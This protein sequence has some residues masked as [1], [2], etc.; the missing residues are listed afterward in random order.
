[1][2]YR[3]LR[4]SRLSLPLAALCFVLVAALAESAVAQQVSRAEATKILSA[5][6]AS[7]ANADKLR[8]Y[9]ADIFRQLQNPANGEVIPTL[10]KD[11]ANTVRG[12]GDN[13][14]HRYFNDLVF[15]GAKAAIGNRNAPPAARY[16]ALL[17]LGDLNQSDAA[18]AIKPYAP[19]LDVLKLA[20][21]VAPDNEDFAFL[22]PA[23]IVGLTRFA[24]EK[25]IP[26]KDIP[27]ITAGLLKIVSDTNPPAGRSASAHNFV[28]RSAAGALA[29]LGNVGPNQS[30]LKAFEAALM[31]PNA[32]T[33]F[34][35]EMMQAIGGLNFPPESK[36]DLTRVANLIGHQ[37][38]DICRQELDRAKAE[39]RPPSRRVLLYALYSGGVG[40]N[41]LNKLAATD[42]SGEAYGFVSGL[43]NKAMAL[44]RTLDNADTTPDAELAAKAETEIQAIQDGL[45]E[46]PTAAA[47]L[48]ARGSS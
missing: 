14:A 3:S 21:N 23:A 11:F 10:R 25:A 9:L 7:G 47:P 13:A 48:A 33:S 39:N 12:V 34:R 18:N 36:G 30:V 15:R 43:R 44:Y 26:P 27:E 41:G 8:S 45:R 38:V 6:D 24:Q 1:M 42:R 37:T 16:N 28:R 2:S 22:K 4:V 31:E 5:G 40:T 46:K 17:L 19:S 32:R 20:L 35:C 29:A